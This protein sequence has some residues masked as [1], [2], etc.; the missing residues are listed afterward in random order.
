MI[1][2]R[3]PDDD[4]T[5]LRYGM[6]RLL[7]ALP[8]VVLFV[9]I[10]ALGL[11]VAVPP[12]G[13]A[14]GWM[15][16]PMGVIGVT[17]F[18]FRW[19]ARRWTTAFDSNGFWWMR[20]GEIALIRWESLAGAGIHW[21]RG[22]KSVVFTLELC[23]KDEID[24]DDPLLWKFVRDADPVRPG[25]P[26]LRYRIDVTDSHKAHEKALRQWAPELWLGRKEQPWSYLGRPDREGHRDRL[27]VRTGAAAGGTRDPLVFD[28]VDIGDT[29][30]VHRGGVLVRR[31]LAAT[32]VM[33]AACAWAVWALVSEHGHGAGAVVRDALAAAL[34]LLTCWAL[35]A[36]ALGVGRIWNQRVTMDAA[37]VH[38][39]RRGQSAT[40][41]W[42]SLAGVGVHGG[43]A[44]HTLELCPKDEIDRDHPL[45]WIFVRDSEPW[46]PGQPRLRHR[47]SIRPDRARHAVAAGCLR[48]APGLWF[49]GERMPAGYEG[50]PDLKGHRRRT[51]GTPDPV[52][53]PAP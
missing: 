24:R 33:V 21:A 5:V 36:I 4:A 45:L 32:S 49:G 6:R 42:E 53:T 17:L 52:V 28:A 38:V 11:W 30:A 18:V 8:F 1:L 34:V 7:W 12:E 35:V 50:A 16:A 15:L 31:R 23:P 39:T 3:W 27:A 46:R 48:W 51:R 19:R 2:G 44:L 9:A 41:P 37:G 22:S 10:G 47:V 13:T 40:V 14:S 29:V 26:R 25:L 20:G 43:P